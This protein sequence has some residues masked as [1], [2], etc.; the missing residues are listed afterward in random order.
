MN[1][2]LLV[3]ALAPTLAVVA[4]VLALSAVQRTDAGTPPPPDGSIFVFTG[5]A[6]L[7]EGFSSFG[8][9]AGR[10][11]VEGAVLPADL[12]PAACVI[13]PANGT[14]FDAGQKTVLSAYVSGGGRLV[15]MAEYDAV[16]PEAVAT[17][18]DLATSLSSSLS[19]VG[20]TL[21]P[22]F[23]T[24][25]N[26]DASAFTSGVSSIVLAATSE[27]A[28]GAS[29]QSLVRTTGST[30]F[31][32]VDQIGSGLF[33]LSGDTN[34]FSNNSGAGYTTEDNGVL[35]NN[36]CGPNRLAAFG[37]LDCGGTVAIA[38]AQKTARALID[39]SVT[40]TEPCPDIGT[41]AA[42]NRV[43]RPWGDVDCT[44]TVS[45]GDAQKIARALVALPVTQTEPCPDIQ[46]DVLIPEA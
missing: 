26:I 23:N 39:L 32:A 10:T 2:P 15:A 9:A 14:A 28:V 44:D 43:D 27:V 29:G 18:N 34:A 30:T 40:Q 6:A 36:M 1:R 4:A 25:T 21:D 16:F 31:V 35:V 11:V 22:G 24:T 19:V 5:N 45:I 38:D 33:F 8:T 3:L 42:V 17:M 20:A 46:E 12:S 7:N 13:L 37:D 41:T